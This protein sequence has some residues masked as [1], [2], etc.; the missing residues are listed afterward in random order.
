MA[1]RSEII[2]GLHDILYDE[3]EGWLTVAQYAVI[4]GALE[5]LKSD[6]TLIENQARIINALGEKEKTDEGYGGL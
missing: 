4:H 6:K 3:H 2:K 5:L 1:D